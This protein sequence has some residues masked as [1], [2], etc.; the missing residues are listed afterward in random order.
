MVARRFKGRCVSKITKEI[1][2]LW[3]AAKAMHGQLGEELVRRAGVISF[4]PAASLPEQTL[5]PLQST[6]LR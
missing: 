1:S 2:I 6:L 4:N 3:R 5:P